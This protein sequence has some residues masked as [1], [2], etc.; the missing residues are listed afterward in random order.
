MGGTHDLGMSV[1]VDSSGN[2]YVTGKFNG[3]VDFDPGTGTDYISSTN[4]KYDIFLIR[5]NANGSYA[6]TKT[7]GGTDQD[8]GDVV[9]VDNSDN[10][11]L[12][13]RFRDT[14]DFDHGTGVDNHTAAG[15]NDVFLTRM[16]ANGTYAWT[17]T[18]EGTGTEWARSMSVDGSG[19]AYMTGFF[20]GSWVDFDPSSSIDYHHASE[21]NIF[22]IRIDA[23]GTYGWTKSMGASYDVRGHFV[24]LDGSGNIYITG[25]FSK[26]VD[27]DPGTGV[28]N[29]TSGGYNLYGGKDIFLTSFNADG[30]Y[31]W[32]KTLGGLGGDMNLSVAVDVS[33]NIYSTGFFWAAV[34]FDPGTGTDIRT[35]VGSRDIF[36]TNF[37]ARV[38]ANDLIIDFG[39]STG[40][41]ARKNNTT[42]SKLHG[43]SP[44]KIITGDIDGSGKSDI[45]ADFGASWGI[46]VKYNNTGSWTRLHGLDP[47]D[48]ATGDID[49][50]G[51]DDVI[52]DFGASTGLWARMNNSTWTKLHGL[53]PEMIKT[54]DI[55]NSG[56]DDIIADF[57][58]SYGIYVKYDNAGSWTYMHGLD[59][60]DF[61]TGDI[62]GNGKDDVIIDF[63]ASTGIWARMNNSTWSKLHGL[64][65]EQIVTGDIDG[66]GKDDLIV[67][68]GSSYGI[69]VKYDN[70]GSWT[71]INGTDPEQIV[72][73]DI[74]SSGKDDIIVD[75]GASWGI[76]IYYNNSGS[77]TYLNGLDPEDMATGNIDGN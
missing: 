45:I 24:A 9:A 18:W 15:I 61:A 55:D 33:G 26:T 67:D 32:T 29:H 66:S 75:F 38:A 77:W 63:G 19:N 71:Q 68:F 48:M 74:D 21:E 5:I 49:G 51:S 30:S 13:G 16:N 27:F 39:S 41:W 25:Q 35:P 12:M 42:W 76:Y 65:P 43:L 46:Y 70:A 4:S 58:A 6:W 47:E 59:P 64:S 3:F 72:I 69:Y 56:K 28:D 60:E 11:Y 34:D 53:S 37:S 14:V 50:N 10:V 52:I 31:G 44:E 62:D 17:R 22:L 8:Y 1:A 23:D 7:I 54:G 36:I 57:G 20:R 73:G 2:I 40:I